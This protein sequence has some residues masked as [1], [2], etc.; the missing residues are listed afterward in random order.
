M[1]DV[2]YRQH[3]DLTDACSVQPCRTALLEHDAAPLQIIRPFSNVIYVSI[4]IYIYQYLKL[5][6]Y[7]YVYI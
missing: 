3:P 5:F 7:I 6:M 2:Q 4:Y 1:D